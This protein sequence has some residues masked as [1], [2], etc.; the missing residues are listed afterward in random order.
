MNLSIS[1]H[2]CASCRIL[3]K[4][5]QQ[6]RR[7]APAILQQAH[8]KTINTLQKEVDRLKALS[9]VNPNVREEEI[10]FFE[11]QHKALVKAID[12]AVPRLDALRVIVTT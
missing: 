12:N 6:A 7:Q 4:C 5:E 9:R 1:H 3:Y 8:A 2:A 10:A 11:T